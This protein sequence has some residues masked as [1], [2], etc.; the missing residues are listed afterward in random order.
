MKQACILPELERSEAVKPYR[1]PSYR[2]ELV[3]EGVISSTV[4]PLHLTNP[5]QVADMLMDHLRLRDRECFLVMLLNTKNSIIGINTV[6]IG[7]LN[8][9]IVHPREIYKPAILKGAASIILIHNHP[10][11]DPSPSQEDLDVTRRVSDA[12]NLLGIPVRD[13]VIIGDGCF[14]SFKEHGLI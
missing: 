9:S 10:S 7:N 14:Y 4:C 6:S 2:V 11:G 13:H 5:R 12:G 3:R 1:V 8:S